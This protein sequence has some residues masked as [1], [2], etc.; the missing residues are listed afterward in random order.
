[1]VQYR[2]NSADNH[3]D[4]RWIPRNLWQARVAARFKNGAPRVVEDA[5]GCWWSWEGK[6]LKG[7]DG[8][9]ADGPDNARILEEFYG[10]SGVQVPPGSLPPADPELVLAHMDL[11]GIYAYVGYA[12]VRKWDIDDPELRMEVHRVYNDWMME[13]NAH[14]GD[15]LLYLPILP[16]F[17]PEA[18]P[19]EIERRAR[20]GAKA[21]EFAI[22][23]ARE[24]VW[25]EAWERTWA[26]AAE[27]GVVL[28]AHIGD[29]AGA[30]YP[31]VE[32]GVRI[33]HFSTVPFSAAAPIAQMTFSGV[34]QRHPKLRL[35]YGE[36]RAGWAPML[37]Y[38][39][40]RQAVERP[41]LYRQSGLELKPSD[42]VRRQITITFEEDDVAGLM[43]RH[44]ESMLR[45]I[46]MWGA[47]YPHPQGVWPDVDP[48]IDRIFEGLPASL[49]Q[50]IV[51]DRCLRVFNLEGPNRRRS[52]PA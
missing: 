7:R 10:P 30:P 28:C 22:F 45:D 20:E 25:H 43:L 32:R 15:R 42:Y 39:M 51:F 1:M 37:L 5:D 6:V 2:Y 36:C 23:D 21:V 8:G 50:E 33:A 18:C 3:L 12:S 40:D 41:D 24:P 49:R 16:T 44:D 27:T 14:D 13:L 52:D 47:D 48:V 4:Q 38:W 9:V 26:T 19:G 29:K 17:D 34:F 11:A 31:P 46:V 35:N